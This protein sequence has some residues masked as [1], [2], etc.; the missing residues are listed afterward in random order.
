MQLDTIFGTAL[1][2]G[3]LTI[4]PNGNIHWVDVDDKVI[5]LSKF[6]EELENNKIKI[7]RE[8]E[9][10]AARKREQEKLNKVGLNIV[11]CGMCGE[12]FAH[13]CNKNITALCCPACGFTEDPCH[14]PDL[15]A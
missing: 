4:R 6:V 11:T 3:L 14:F 1:S 7:Q 5:A 12:A 8:L 9:I 15:F 2:A 13:L 10:K